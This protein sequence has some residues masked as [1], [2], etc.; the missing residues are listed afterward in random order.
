MF[1][2]QMIKVYKVKKLI[3]HWSFVILYGGNKS[4]SKKSS[5]YKTKRNDHRVKIKGGSSISE[6][7]CKKLRSCL[8]PKLFF[9]YKSEAER[10]V[11]AESS[12]FQNPVLSFYIGIST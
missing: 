12:A 9:S 8:P 7:T 1:S 4:S 3:L 2:L 11:L 5:K 10:V 6:N